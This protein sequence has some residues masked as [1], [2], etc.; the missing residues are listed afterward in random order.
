MDEVITDNT[1]ASEFLRFLR[2]A[3]E[4]MEDGPE[5]AEVLMDMNR[6]LVQLVH[7]TNCYQLPAYES[8]RSV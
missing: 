3:S 8:E 7:L 1:T 4:V 6:I 5:K 2:D